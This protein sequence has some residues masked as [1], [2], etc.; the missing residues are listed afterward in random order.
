[1]DINYTQN[2]ALMPKRKKTSK[3]PRR[4]L[5]ASARPSKKANT[6][7]FNSNDLAQFK[8]LMRLKH[9]NPGIFDSL[10]QDVEHQQPNRGASAR[11]SHSGSESPPVQDR[12]DRISSS[13]DEAVQDDYETQK[14]M[15][16]P[17]GT[18]HVITSCMLDTVVYVF[19][20]NPLAGVF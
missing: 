9:N 18:L 19:R 16:D 14:R 8:I 3:T 13:D 1:M 10:L 6:I 20:S 17:S 12:S 11:P 2:S 5:G 15:W 7:E 4:R